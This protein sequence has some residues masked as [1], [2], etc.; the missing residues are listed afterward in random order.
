MRVELWRM[1]EA[2]ARKAARDSIRH[3]VNSPVA[4]LLMSLQNASSS[5]RIKNISYPEGA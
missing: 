1:S 4:T 5:L 3:S 2:Q